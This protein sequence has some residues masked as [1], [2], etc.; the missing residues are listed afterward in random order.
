MYIDAF[1]NRPHTAIDIVTLSSLFITTLKLRAAVRLAT[2]S[3][4]DNMSTTV[5]YVSFAFLQLMIFSLK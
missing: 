5:L 4:Q 3:I 2:M 1:I